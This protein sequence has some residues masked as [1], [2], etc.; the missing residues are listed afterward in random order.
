[1]HQYQLLRPKRLLVVAQYLQVS[2]AAAS[3]RRVHEV[4]VAAVAVAAAG[5][6]ALSARVQ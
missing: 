4:G 2:A 3:Q 5:M 1:M 6:S